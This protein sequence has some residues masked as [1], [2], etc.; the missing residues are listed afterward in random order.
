MHFEDTVKLALGVSGIVAR[1]VA[2]GTA[3]DPNLLGGSQ[4]DFGQLNNTARVVAL[5]RAPS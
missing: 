1:Y 2:F 3:L 4:L 5:A